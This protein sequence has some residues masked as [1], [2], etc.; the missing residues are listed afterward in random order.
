MSEF[1]YWSLKH[2]ATGWGA[3][4]VATQLKSAWLWVP[5][6]VAALVSFAC[7]WHCM[8]QIKKGSA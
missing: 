6:M 1:H 7:D 3:L 8:K 5:L 2:T 4:I